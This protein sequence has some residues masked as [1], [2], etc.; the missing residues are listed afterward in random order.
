LKLAVTLQDSS[1]AQVVLYR[2][3][4]MVRPI[5]WTGRIKFLPGLAGRHGEDALAK[6]RRASLA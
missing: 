1:G 4:D 6:G 2:H 5:G 3:A